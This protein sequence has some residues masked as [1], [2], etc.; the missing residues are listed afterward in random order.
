MPEFYIQKLAEKSEYRYYK[1]MIVAALC[2]KCHGNVD[3]LDPALKK[4]LADNYPNDKAVNY[5]IDDFRGLIRVSIPA[6]LISK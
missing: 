1:P 6:D 2:Q 3:Q 4:S 5:Q